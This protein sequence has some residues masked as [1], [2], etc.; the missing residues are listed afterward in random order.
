[1]AIKSNLDQIPVRKMEFKL[2]SAGIPYLS[3]CPDFPETIEIRPFSLETEAILVSNKTGNEKM[4]R[5]TE[6]VVTLPQPLTVNDLL[7]AD[8]FVILAIAR[9]LTYGETYKF[10]VTCPA[11][12]H[13]EEVNVQIP[14]QLPV[15]VWERTKVVGEGD[16]ASSSPFLYPIEITLPTCK[17]RVGVQFLT[18]GADGSMDRF[19]KQLH[20]ASRGSNQDAA[21]A[22]YLRRLAHSVV[23]VNGGAPEH[24]EEAV[25]YVKRLQG[26]DMAAFKKAV[27]DNAC[28]IDYDWP[29]SCDA[30]QHIYSAS[31]PIA[32]DF[33]RGNRE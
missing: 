28:G 11:C 22:A 26:P 14:E 23:S 1:M 10:H 18:V 5:I 12:R 30:C 8:Q 20:A 27:D 2:P 21:Q 17:D 13:R 7:V 24:V 3:K 25:E 6:R 31:F 4:A 9:A 29:I 15:K 16:K 33:F 19:E 32:S